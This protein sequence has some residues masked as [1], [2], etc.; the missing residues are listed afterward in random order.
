[1]QG[2]IEVVSGA[3][4]ITVQDLGR[5]NVSQFGMSQG[6]AADPLS[7]KLANLLVG[8]TEDCAA[9]E[10][11]F[12]ALTLRILVPIT[13]SFTGAQCSLVINKLTYPLW[14]SYTL[15]PGDIIE[16]KNCGHQTINYI[17]ISGGFCSPSIYCS[18][19]TIIREQIGLKINN[20]DVLFA[21][22]SS[23]S[24]ER[25]LDVNAIA[26][27]IVNR[28]LY[29]VPSYQ[30]ANFSQ[31]ARQ[32]FFSN[33]HRIGLR[34]NRMGVELTGNNISPPKQQLY[35]EGIALGAIQVPPNG[36][37]IVLLNDRQTIGGYAKIGTLVSSDCAVLSQL[38]ASSEVNFKK[39]SFDFA[40]T[41][42]IEQLKWYRELKQQIC[43]K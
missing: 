42:A 3:Q 32:L 19:S 38:P 7:F 8:N 23:I 39:V 4:F 15:K 12:A 14:Q 11:H 16:L 40:K 36:N 22:K 10:V 18:H 29:V 28:P 37:P 43:K 34:S 1:M 20:N 27:R 6:G 35:S 24:R 30:H 21:K 33:T 9:L 25:K 26:A 17:S 2:L 13:V 31:R 41:H 5:N